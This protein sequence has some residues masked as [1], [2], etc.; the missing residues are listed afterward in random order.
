VPEVTHPP[1]KRINHIGLLLA[2]QAINKVPFHAVF[3]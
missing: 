2:N 3:I 1:A